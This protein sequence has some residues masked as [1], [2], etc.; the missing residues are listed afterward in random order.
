MMTKSHFKG[1]HD[2]NPDWNNPHDKYCDGIEA[3]AETIRERGK[4]YGSPLANHI[5]IARFWS[6]ILDQEI[7]PSMVVQ[8]MIAVKL[9][10]IKHKE[11]HA[12]SW[13]DI[14]GYA[15]LGQGFIK[16]E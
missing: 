1:E 3:V 8:C 4:D 10:R 2:M 9:A 15:G 14:I 16:N 5:E 6:V 13:H 12:D 11:N 7:T